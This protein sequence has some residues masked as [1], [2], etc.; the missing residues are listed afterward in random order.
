MLNVQ[1]RIGPGKREVGLGWAFGERNS[2]REKKEKKE[3]SRLCLKTIKLGP[4]FEIK[5]MFE[6]RI[7]ERRILWLGDFS[8]LL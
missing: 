2:E 6:R 5:L 1:R 4:K 3:K 7:E 8:Y